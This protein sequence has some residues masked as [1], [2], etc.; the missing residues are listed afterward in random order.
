MAQVEDRIVESFEKGGG[1]A[2]S[3]YNRFNEVM[4]DESY[5]TVVTPLVDT[6]I[7]LVDGLKEKLEEGIDVLDVGCGSGKA[8]L[9]LAKTFPKSRFTGYDFLDS[10]VQVAEAEAKSVSLPTLLLF[11]KMYPLLMI[12]E[13][14]IWFLRLML[15]MIKQSRTKC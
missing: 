14:M 15:Y 3:E 12:R 13:S 8:I 4:A 1:L 2:Y 7:P 6:L 10:A 11:R 5:Q 9:A